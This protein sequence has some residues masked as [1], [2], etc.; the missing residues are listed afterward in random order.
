MPLYELERYLSLHIADFPD[1]DYSRNKGSG[2]LCWYKLILMDNLG[3]PYIQAPQFLLL[4]GFFMNIWGTSLIIHTSFILTFYNYDLISLTFNARDVTVTL[5]WMI[6]GTY[7]TVILCLTICPSSTRI[8][9]TEWLAL[10]LRG[11]GCQIITNLCIRTIWIGCAAYFRARYKRISLHSRR[12]VT[13]SFMS[14]GFTFCP[15]STTDP[16]ARIFAFIVLTF[17]TKRTIIV[18]LA[19]I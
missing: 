9:C 15:T 11:G 17:F 18:H 13:N 19:F 12:A 1:M 6:T 4:K 3:R 5:Q 7:F 2:I 16:Q 10:L 8:I 14:F